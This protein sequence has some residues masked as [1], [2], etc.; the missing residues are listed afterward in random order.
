MASQQAMIVA[1]LGCRRDCAAQDVL[2]AIA[3]ALAAAG[4]TAAE[5]SALYAPESK[6]AESGL[7]LAAAQL[8]K[9]LAFLAWAELEAQAPRVL[10]RSARVL[11]QTGVPCVA[12]TAALA[13]ARGAASTRLL[14]PRQSFGGATCAL[15]SNEY[16]T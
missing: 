7:A 1:G 5:L 9:P 6:R 12:E 2:A 10:T 15:A 4:K 3:R 13:G 11:A 14:G 8:G 16:S